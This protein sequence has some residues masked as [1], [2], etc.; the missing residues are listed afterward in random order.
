MPLNFGSP[1]HG[2]E[3]CGVNVQ[4]PESPGS[5]ALLKPLSYVLRSGDAGRYADVIARSN[6]ASTFADLVKFLLMVRKKVKD[7]QARA[8]APMLEPTCRLHRDLV[9]FPFMVHEAAKGRAGAP[10]GSSATGRVCCTWK[11]ESYPCAVAQVVVRR[12]W[13]IACAATPS[14]SSAAF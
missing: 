12:T 4:W 1:H 14:S 7:P 9:T 13:Q 10:A 8:Q 2:L 5:Q 11:R 3:H 6:E